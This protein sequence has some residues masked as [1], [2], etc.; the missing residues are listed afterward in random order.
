M[1]LHDA[2]NA[3]HLEHQKA[4]KVVREAALARGERFFPSARPEIDARR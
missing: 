3:T 4:C 2:V 1:I